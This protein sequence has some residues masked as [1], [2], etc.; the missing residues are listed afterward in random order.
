MR[1]D[2]KRKSII[3]WINLIEYLVKNQITKI[4]VSKEYSSYKII[5]KIFSHPKFI[6]TKFKMEVIIKCSS[7]NFDH[8]NFDQKKLINEIKNYKKDLKIK[9]FYAVQWLSR[10]NLNNNKKRLF[11][12]NKDKKLINSSIKI[13][14]KKYSKFFLLFP[15]S[16]TFLEACIAL[17]RMDGFTIYLN[18]EEKNYL[19]YLKFE[20]FKNI[21]IR[22]FIKLSQDK[23]NLRLKKILRLNIKKR[24]ILGT[25]IS[26]SKKKQIDQII[27]VINEKN[28]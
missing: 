7:P 23:I 10:G 15:Y 11:F 13:I 20:K 4:H 19:K 9:K 8:N 5:K 14:K 2:K 17:I 6:K 18:L 16:E 21:T 3:Y 26:I 25:M 12:L 28:F 24:N 1:M 27:N 22:P